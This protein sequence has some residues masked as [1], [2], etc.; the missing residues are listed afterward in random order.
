M[1][2]FAIRGLLAAAALFLGAGSAH[3]ADDYTL[4]FYDPAVGISYG[5]DRDPR[6]CVQ[7][8]WT[9]RT[10]YDCNTHYGYV[11]DN[12][13]GIDYPMGL[14]SDV[15]SAK[16]GRVIDAFD[17]FDT[18]RFGPDGNFVLLQ[19][20]DGRRTIY[21]H[22]A[23]NGVTVSVGTPVSAGQLIARSGCSGLC[24]G[25]HLHY[26]LLRFT[27]RW[28]STDPNA[29]RRWTTWPGRVP[30]LAAYVRENNGG[31]EVVRRGQT[32]THWVEFRNTGGRVWWNSPGQGRLT[33]ATWNPAGRASGFQALDWSASWIPTFMDNTRVGI[34]QVGRFTFGLSGN[35]SP[36][37]YN[38]YFNLL[39]SGLRWF[40]HGRLGGFYV[41]VI[42]TR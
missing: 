17:G 31:A 1:T 14:F 29:E 30:Y 15:A 13:T 25:A 22:L 12:H 42:V 28:Q 11:Y 32:I 27:D 35:P 3:A 2:R 24:Y 20:A 16:A 10:W 38:E 26:E 40:D 33:L 9:G 19:H 6:Q 18:Q 37:S 23:Q 34:D 21:Y 7:L 41:P 4:P 5:V 8:D 36:G 39:A